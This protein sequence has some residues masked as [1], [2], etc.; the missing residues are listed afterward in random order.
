MAIDSPTLYLSLAT[1]QL[2]AALIGLGFALWSCRECY[3][4]RA[5]QRE[6]GRNGV[7]ALVAEAHLSAARL[8][9]L[10]QSAVGASATAGML[11][12]LSESPLPDI[13]MLSR[14]V[15][16]CTT[17]GLLLVLGVVLWRARLRL[18]QALDERR[19]G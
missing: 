2:A 1:V 14:Y 19:A 13:Y 3:R 4:D 5:A 12:A 17:S 11:R 10:I 16:A 15:F 8:L 7:L 6:T 9:V 18:L